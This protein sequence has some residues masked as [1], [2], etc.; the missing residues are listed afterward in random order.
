M[1]F[2][3]RDFQTLLGI[4]NYLYQNCDQRVL[5]WSYRWENIKTE[6]ENYKIDVS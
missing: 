4:N 3:Y 2:I 1:Y 5:P 6:L